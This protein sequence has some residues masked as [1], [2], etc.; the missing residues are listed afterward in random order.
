MRDWLIERIGN[1]QYPGLVWVN[2]KEGVFKIPWKHG[3]LHGF[4]QNDALI[5]KDWG[6]HTGKI[7][8]SGLFDIR[9]QITLFIVL[10]FRYE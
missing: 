6:I 3:A 5:F 10:Y 1:Y 2:K 8:E 9:L 7:K 4:S